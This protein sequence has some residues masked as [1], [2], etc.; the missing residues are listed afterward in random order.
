[1]SLDFH[2][3][4]SR[5]EAERQRPVFSVEEASHALLAQSVNSAAM[6]TKLIARIV[7]YYSDAE[8]LAEEIDELILELRM[9]EG[10]TAL[11]VVQD[12][13]VICEK[14]VSAKANLYVFCD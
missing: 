2:I 8:F 14:T 7:D 11:Q 10:E 9:L 4:Y 13:L 1:M 3:S 6:P 12:L 5:R